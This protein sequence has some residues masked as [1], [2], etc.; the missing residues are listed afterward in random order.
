MLI[1]P[2]GSLLIQVGDRLVLRDAKSHHHEFIPRLRAL[3]CQTNPDLFDGLHLSL[4]QLAAFLLELSLPADRL[5][6]QNLRFDLAVNVEEVLA[7]KLA[8]FAEVRFELFEL[9]C[10]AHRDGITLARVGEEGGEKSLA[11]GG[12][13]LSILAYVQ[14]ALQHE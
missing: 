10:L 6:D 7:C 3:S 13:V 11:K 8:Q 9:G 12:C 2:S 5:S 4:E 1:S 14:A